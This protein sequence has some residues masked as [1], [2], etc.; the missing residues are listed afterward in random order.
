MRG[1][2]GMPVLVPSGVLGLLSRSAPTPPKLVMPGDPLPLPPLP[3]LRALPGWSDGSTSGG[4]C[5]LAPNNG[6]VGVCR[7]EFNAAPAASG[8]TLDPNEPEIEPETDPLPLPLEPVDM[9]RSR[10][11]TS[12]ESGA[13][14]LGPDSCSE[15]ESSA[16]DSRRPSGTLRITRDT[17]PVNPDME[18]AAPPAAPAPAP[19]DR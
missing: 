17:K 11:D 1:N 3:V 15:S 19:C 7:P 13:G 9:V 2:G 5:S 6:S 10:G 12:G 8:L 14:P 18:P 16:E 4:A